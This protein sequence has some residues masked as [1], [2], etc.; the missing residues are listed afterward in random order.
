MVSQHARNLFLGFVPHD[1]FRFSTTNSIS[2]QNFLCESRKC[3]QVAFSILFFL[4]EIIKICF[5]LLAMKIP[6][7]FKENTIK[8]C[9][10]IRYFERQCQ[11]GRETF[12]QLVDHC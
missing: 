9:H 12:I 1:F 8:M 11:I 2:D 5:F 10:H 6:K 7:S 3:V 4:N